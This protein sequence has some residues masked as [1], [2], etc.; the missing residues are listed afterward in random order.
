MK[1]HLLVAAALLTPVMLVHAQE[2]PL[3]KRPGF[4]L[5]TKTMTELGLTEEQKNKIEQS[6]NAFRSKRKVFELEMR[7]LDSLVL[8]R[9][10][11]VLTANQ[12]SVVAPLRTAIDQDQKPTPGYRKSLII[13]DTRLGAELGF[14]DEQQKKFKEIQRDY[15]HLRGA[16]GSKFSKV[17]A[18]AILE[19]ENVLNNSQQKRMAEIKAEIEAHNKSIN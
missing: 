2:Q 17:T 19:Q 5:D 16:G 13:F 1:I 3:K 7:Q 18:D 9:Q 8:R 15:N 4:T 11:S 10:D 6:R 12:R 14:N